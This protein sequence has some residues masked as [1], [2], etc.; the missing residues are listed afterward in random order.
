MQTKF[1][2]LKAN[3][4]KLRTHCKP[5]SRKELGNKR[6]QATIDVLLDILC[7][8]NHK[9]LIRKKPNTVGLSANQVGILK[10]ISIVDLAIGNKGI[11]DIHALI[12]PKIVWCSKAVA[13][14]REG[15]VNLPEIWGV[16]PRHKEIKVEALD[17]SGNRIS[18][19]LKG[20]PARLLQHE[21]DHLNGRLYIDRLADSCKAHVVKNSELPR[22]RKQF[23]RWKHYI[24]V[25]GLIRKL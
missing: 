25:S 15:C 1:R 22:Y 20:L 8:R 17:R 2:P 4:K 19:H 11:N 5:V 13:Q 21:V 9:G 12:N 23:R 18:L 7:G 24:D 14:G 3:D 10:R 6:T 16:I